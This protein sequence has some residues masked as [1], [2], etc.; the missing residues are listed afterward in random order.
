MRGT[1]II[2]SKYEHTKHNFIILDW[3]IDNNIMCK[4]V[5]FTVFMILYE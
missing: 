2:H 3:Q 4:F 5:S 1:F